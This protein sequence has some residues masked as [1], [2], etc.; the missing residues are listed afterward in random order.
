[1][2]AEKIQRQLVHHA[3]VLVDEIRAGVLVARRTALDKGSFPPPD[4]LPGDGSNRLH[5]QSLCHLS[6]P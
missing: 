1:M 3:L 4:F 6:T 2:V 5:R